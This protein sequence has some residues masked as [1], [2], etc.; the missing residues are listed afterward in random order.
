M[1]GVRQP[2][3]LSPFSLFVFHHRAVYKGIRDN[4]PDDRPLPQGVDFKEYWPMYGLGTSVTDSLLKGD[5]RQNPV[6]HDNVTT[7]VVASN[8]G[9]V[10]DLFD[11][12]FSRQALMDMGLRPDTAIACAFSYLFRPRQEVKALYADTWKT[13]ADPS[14]LK[15]GI[16]I[17]LG[18]RMFMGNNT[19]PN[20][21]NVAPYFACA[22]EI[23]RTRALPGQR[24]VYFMMSDSLALRRL[25]KSRLGEKLLTDVD[26]STAHV[27][28]N[29]G[30]CAPER[31]G[32]ALRYA[33]GD[34]ITFSMAN[35][36]VYT[37]ES[38]FGRIGAWISLH[39]HNHY[40]ID[41]KN[42]LNGYRNCGIDSYDAL[43]EDARAWSGVR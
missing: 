12:P 43:K 39:W 2:T 10:W 30:N 3:R 9:R 17:R 7:V 18:D 15:I 6:G 34:L 25:A 13:M 33:V 21:D 29:S 36:H 22:Q 42:S 26:T 32:L 1:L 23:E 35:F 5:I 41:V 16:Q 28:C 27:A 31:Q 14:I 19:A 24:V 37:R 20:W 11:N 38:G 40:G 8:R 4:A